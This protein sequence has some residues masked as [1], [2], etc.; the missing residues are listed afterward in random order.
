VKIFRELQRELA[1]SEN[2]ATPWKMAM[3]SAR[4]WNFPMI[5]KRRPPVV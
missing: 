4:K 1:L 3:A 5:F 2:D